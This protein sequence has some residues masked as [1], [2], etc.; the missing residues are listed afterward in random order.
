MNQGPTTP[1]ITRID[2]D[3]SLAERL[4]MD[5]EMNRLRTGLVDASFELE[6]LKREMI[7]LGRQKMKAQQELAE[8]TK[9]Q[10]EALAAAQNTIAAL[11]AD[12]E[13]LQREADAARASVQSTE[14]HRKHLATTISLNESL[15]AS[16]KKEHAEMQRRAL[17]AEDRLG[18]VRDAL[19]LHPND[20]LLNAIDALKDENEDGGDALTKARDEAELA[21]LEAVKFAAVHQDAQSM[22]FAAQAF[23]A[24]RGAE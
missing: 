8:A 14:S 6:G 9:S 4:E 18:A 17:D 1:N 2:R 21:V 23:A 12:V 7:S 5:A 13:K 24:L 10:S 19:D 15:I 20:S 11:R 16:L 22:S 3:E